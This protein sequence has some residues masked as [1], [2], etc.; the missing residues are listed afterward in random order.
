MQEDRA[1]L[2]AARKQV[3]LERSVNRKLLQSKADVEYRLMEALSQLPQPSQTSHGEHRYMHE[4][5]A[6]SPL[7]SQSHVRDAGSL[8]FIRTSQGAAADLPTD[9]YVARGG[10]S[11]PISSATGSLPMHAFP[12]SDHSTPA[13]SYRGMTMHTSMRASVD[14]GAVDRM[15][16]ST[17]SVGA[18][19]RGVH[20]TEHRSHSSHSHR[21][22]SP[23]QHCHSPVEQSGTYLSERECALDAWQ[24]TRSAVAACSPSGEDGSTRVF[25]Q[26]NHTTSSQ[27]HAP[28]ALSRAPE[29]SS[30]TGAAGDHH[31]VDDFPS[32]ILR[33]S[34]STANQQGASVADKRSSPQGG[35]QGGS[36]MEQVWA[37][38]TLRVPAH[39]GTKGSVCSE[40]DAG[41][42]NGFAA[43]AAMQEQ[44][45][46][47][48][49]PSHD[50]WQVAPGGVRSSQFGFGHEEQQENVLLHTNVVRHMPT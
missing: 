23:L 47:A 7:G 16:H 19:G 9:S 18:P 13:D 44:Q 46:A 34:S 42:R 49:S 12:T 24:D 8:P 32:D 50:K 39:V 20:H 14:T 17:G 33:C 3:E 38:G 43:C 15:H 11:S 30:S 4:T 28:E 35:S 6:A 29:P 31:R 36:P 41:A 45:S 25:G 40:S 5:S 21:R 27:G 26:S 1:S 37:S 10:L 2:S 22:T 48:S